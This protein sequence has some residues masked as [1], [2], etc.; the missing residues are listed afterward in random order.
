MLSKQAAAHALSGSVSAALTCL[1]AM[2]LLTRPWLGSF[3]ILGTSPA[4]GLIVVAYLLGVR[5]VYLDQQMAKSANVE[6]GNQPNAAHSKMTL[7]MALAGFA[8]CAAAIL[9]AG[10]FLAHA[11]DALA[12]K[13]GL[14]GTFVGTTLVA[15]ST[16]LPELVS[17][18]AALRMGAP[19]LAIGNVFGSN[20]FNVILLAP[21]D[22]VH[23]GPLMAAVSANHAI[24]CV[25]AILATQVAV[26]GQ[27]YQSEKR[28]YLIE[29]DAGL[30]ILIVAGALVLVYF[31]R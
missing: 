26:M 17:S 7:W 18:L 30:V 12:E 9:V 15:L 2:S 14:G 22:L 6:A 16:S 11:A 20:A 21:L 8:G 29:P 28:T 23:P 25:A 13:S 27:L 4:V 1:V 19:D 5:L 31:C 3:A 24:T 10:P